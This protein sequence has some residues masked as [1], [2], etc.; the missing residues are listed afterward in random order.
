M[1][2][3]TALS[4]SKE[5]RVCWAA[6]YGN[7]LEFRAGSCASLGLGYAHMSSIPALSPPDDFTREP[8]FHVAREYV[9]QCYPGTCAGNLCRI[10]S[11]ARLMPKISR[12]YLGICDGFGS[13]G[14]PCPVGTVG[15]DAYPQNLRNVRACGVEKLDRAVSRLC[16]RTYVRG[17]GF[18]DDCPSGWRNVYWADVTR[19]LVPDF[20][21]T[22]PLR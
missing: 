7:G 4:M 20:V 17:G 6:I 15:A 18:R 10:R 21:Q 9:P 19:E 1:S 3:S 2:G 14:R 11:S 5:A 16:K 12:C 8:R 13:G 22:F